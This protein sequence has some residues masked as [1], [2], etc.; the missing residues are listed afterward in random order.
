MGMKPD[1]SKAPKPG[2]TTV[3]VG[4]CVLCRRSIFPHQPYGRAPLPW[5]GLAH[6]S[7]G[8]CPGLAG[9]RPAV[10]P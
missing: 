7:T 5:L 9:L 2:L 4:A 1:V 8:D 3:E 10:A 6:E